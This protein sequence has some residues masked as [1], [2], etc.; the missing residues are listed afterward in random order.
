MV[1]PILPARISPKFRPM[2]YL[3]IVVVIALENRANPD[4]GGRIVVFLIPTLRN[5]L[6]ERVVDE[7]T[8]LAI[9]EVPIETSFSFSL[10]HTRVP[11][12]RLTTQAILPH[13]IGLVGTLAV[14]TVSLLD[15]P[16]TLLVAVLVNLAGPSSG[17]TTGRL[18]Y[19]VTVPITLPANAPGVA[20]AF[21]RT[22]GSIVTIVVAKPPSPLGPL[23]LEC[24]S[25]NGPRLG[26]KLLT[27]LKSN[28]RPL[29]TQKRP[30]VLPLDNFRV[31]T[32]SN[33]W[34]VTLVLVAFVLKYTQARPASPLS[35]TPT[36]LRTLVNATTLAFR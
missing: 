30:C 12:V 8:L 32:L 33:T 11:P 20:E 27:L 5:L 10:G 19:D 2:V 24:V 22:A 21:M 13:L 26:A 35:P 16:T 31:I 15:Y 6:R 17:K 25:V 28:F 3:V 23:N 7:T 34:L 36:V 29:I 4:I 9:R 14:I 18:Y 1:P